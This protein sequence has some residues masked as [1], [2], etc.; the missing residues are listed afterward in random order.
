MSVVRI[1][2]RGETESL[3]LGE[4]TDGAL[5]HW[6]GMG[7]ITYFGGDGVRNII[8]ISALDHITATKETTE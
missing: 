2:R 1:W 6:L 7:L 3:N 4:H 8:P 5:N